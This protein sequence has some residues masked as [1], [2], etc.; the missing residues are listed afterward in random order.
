MLDAWV[1][2][3][4]LLNLAKFNVDLDTSCN[5]VWE[6]TWWIFFNAKEKSI[7]SYA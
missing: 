2:V 3:W 6:H 1:Q 7:F 4:G 5:W